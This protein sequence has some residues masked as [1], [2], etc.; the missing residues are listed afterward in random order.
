MKVS[1]EGFLL[2]NLQGIDLFLSLVDQMVAAGAVDGTFE[3]CSKELQRRIRDYGKR[4][5]DWKIAPVSTALPEP[6][7]MTMG[8]LLERRTCN[9]REYL[10]LK[11]NIVYVVRDG[12]QAI[13]VGSTR[14][15][16]R[17]RMKSHQK[18]HSRLGNALRTN[19]DAMN[20]SVEMI[21]HAAISEAI[22]KEKR[23]I[24]QL[25]PRFNLK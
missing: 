2:L 23:L 8:V 20:W 10:T 9:N 25:R 18:A 19:P 3:G 5:D 15:D 24:A 11:S 6:L 12:E 4:L 22:E 14:Y 17:T 16:A 7:T 13:Y 21:A 1:T